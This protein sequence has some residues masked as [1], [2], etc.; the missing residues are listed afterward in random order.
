MSADLRVSMGI[1]TGPLAT[2]LSAARQS[3]ASFAS[4]VGG[5]LSG[6]LS[7]AGVIG[8]ARALGSM[9]GE[10]RDTADATGLSVE[11]VQKLGGAFSEGGVSSQKFSVAMGRLNATL[12]EAGNGNKTAQATLQSLGITLGDLGSITPEQALM[13]VADTLAGIHDPAERA[14]LAIDLFGRGGAAM[15]PTLSQGS[16]AIAKMGEGFSALSDSAITA[17]DA[18]SERMDRFFKKLYALPVLIADAVHQIDKATVD[19]KVIDAANAMMNSSDP[20]ERERGHILARNILAGDVTKPAATAAST[21]PAPALTRTVRDL[22]GSEED[23]LASLATDGIE[24][25]NRGKKIATLDFGPTEEEFIADQEQRSAR[26]DSLRGDTDA[27]RRIGGSLG[28]VNYGGVKDP[29]QEK[30]LKVSQDQ[31]STLKR[32]EEKTGSAA[33][34]AQ[35]SG[36]F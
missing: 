24:V 10:I 27:L 30:F 21:A 2:G 22:S 35:F 29:L 25:K 26:N 23:F 19:N 15:I 17:I 20:L 9:S 34:A 1:D 28:G 33:S 8:Y 31:L 11:A 14:R 7:V 12:G 4:G 6:A 32:I 16:A 5:M 36:N 18:A 13:R 3:V